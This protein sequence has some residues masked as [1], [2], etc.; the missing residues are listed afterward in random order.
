MITSNLITAEISR[1]MAAEFPSATVYINACPTGFTRPAYLVQNAKNRYLDINRNTVSVTAYFTVT[2]YPTVDA[3]NISDSAALYAAQEK[4]L[5]IFHDGYLTVGDRK[6]KA[7]RSLGGMNSD[8]V[9]I[10]VLFR[11]FDDRSDAEDSTPLIASVTT[12][13]AKK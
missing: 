10:K 13:I 8:G 1:L 4:I 6:I 7:R 9:Y 11:Y 5:S 3:N 2:Y 12:K